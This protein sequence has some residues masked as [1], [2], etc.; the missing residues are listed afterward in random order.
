MNVTKIGALL[1]LLLLPGLVC[2]CGK[3]AKRRAGNR[4]EG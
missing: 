1:I 4:L 3:L 2:G